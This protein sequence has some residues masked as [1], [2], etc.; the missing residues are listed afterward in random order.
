MKDNIVK[1]DAPTKNLV[2]V[3]RYCWENKGTAMGLT[4]GF[5]YKPGGVPVVNQL[6]EKGVYMSMKTGEYTSVDSL[7]GYTTVWDTSRT[8]YVVHPF[9]NSLVYKALEG[10]D[11]KSNPDV[12]KKTLKG[13]FATLKKFASIK[14]GKAEGSPKS[15]HARMNHFYKEAERVF[16]RE[17]VESLLPEICSYFNEKEKDNYKRHIY[18]FYR[19]IEDYM[20]Q[21][22]ELLSSPYDSFFLNYYGS[23]EER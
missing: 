22:R 4:V 17:K 5:L 12:D 20:D 6:H 3:G 7:K 21:L 23:L 2:I 8:D 9:F 19:Y 10:C 16:P 15:T 13:I 11:L 14:N 1:K 18:D